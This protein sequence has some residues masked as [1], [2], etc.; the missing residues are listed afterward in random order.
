MRLVAESIIRNTFIRKYGMMENATCCK[1]DP[2]CGIVPL[3]SG[4][5]R[6]GSNHP[7]GHGVL[8]L[9]RYLSIYACK[10][11]RCCETLVR[12]YKWLFDRFGSRTRASTTAS[13]TIRD[14]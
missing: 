7:V 6:T 2:M 12:L 10:K 5:I 8:P 4:V 11:S 9:T 13:K 3:G 14:I 1:S